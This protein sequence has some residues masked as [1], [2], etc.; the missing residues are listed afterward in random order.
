MTEERWLPVVGYEGAYEVSNHGRARSLDRVKKYKDGRQ[1][2]WP[3]KLL[4]LRPT[5][6][7]YLRFNTY[8]GDVYIHRAVLE[9][10]VG[11]CPDGQEACHNDSNRSNNYVENLRWDTRFGNCQDIK[12][13]GSHG[14]TQKTHC[15]NGHP[16]DGQVKS[17]GGRTRRYCKLCRNERARARYAEVG[18]YGARRKSTAGNLL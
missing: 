5:P 11:P 17:G 14:N 12:A 13:I 10:F 4:K 2:F 1:R 16:Y 18:P 6:T 3:G 9:A 15:P 7:G 8:R